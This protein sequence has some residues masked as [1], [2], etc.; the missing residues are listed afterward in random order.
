MCKLFG[1]NFYY[2]Y[3][4]SCYQVVLVGHI[5]GYQTWEFT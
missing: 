3:S 2:F 1:C 4:Q 5:Q